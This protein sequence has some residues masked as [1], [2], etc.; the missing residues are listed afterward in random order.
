VVFPREVGDQ[1]A[2]YTAF[3]KIVHWLGSLSGA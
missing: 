3:D 2:L 1:D